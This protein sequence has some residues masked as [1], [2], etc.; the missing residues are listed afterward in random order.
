M[1]PLYAALALM[2]SD[3]HEQEYTTKK[4]IASQS[5]FARPCRTCQETR[6]FANTKKICALEAWYE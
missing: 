5:R 2:Y 6:N 3:S 1:P 4:Q